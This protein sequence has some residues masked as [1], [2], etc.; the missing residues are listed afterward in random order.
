MILEIAHFH[1]VA[2]NNEGFEQAAQQAEKIL[3]SMPG[4]LGHQLHRC[5]EDETEYRLLVE[6]N[7]VED[8]TERFRRSTR[9]TEWRAL[10]QPFFS[11]PPIATHFERIRPGAC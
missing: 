7:T 5:I 4:Y 8:H 6:W 1:I 11:A 3:A 9:F 2:G 10:L